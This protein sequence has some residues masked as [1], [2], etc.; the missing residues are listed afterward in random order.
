M[1]KRKRVSQLPEPVRDELHQQLIARGFSGYEELAG[2]LRGLGYQI[3]KSSLHRYAQGFED[4]LAALKLSSEQA[5]AV[6]EASPDAEGA[7]SDALIRLVQE[8]LFSLLVDVNTVDEEGKPQIDLAKVARA[9]A[10]LSRTTVNLRKYQAQ[11]KERAEA[12]AKAVEAMGN[13]SGL[14]PE[15]VA[16]IQQEI[17]GI[18]A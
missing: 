5:R 9:V 10:D 4:R 18:A 17:Y 8:R 14:T 7:M 12:A 13:K 11:V 1:A 3:S 6:V 15:L 16:R 2:W